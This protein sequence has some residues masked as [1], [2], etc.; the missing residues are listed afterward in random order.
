MTHYDILEVT[1][2][3]DPAVIEKAYRALASKYHPDRAHGSDRENADRRMARLNEAYRVLRDPVSRKRY[4]ATL[5]RRREH[6]W[7][8]FMERGLVGLF[9]DRLHNAD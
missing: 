7:D 1:R 9:L 6:G 2:E 3:A 5:P 4:D 8:V